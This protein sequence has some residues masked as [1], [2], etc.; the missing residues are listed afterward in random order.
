MGCLR[1]RGYAKGIDVGKLIHDQNW[2][3]RNQGKFY[4]FVEK[5]MAQL[6]KQIK[7]LKGVCQNLADHASAG[8]TTAMLGARPMAKHNTTYLH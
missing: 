8:Y 6:Q 4:I 7:D 1:T 2:L 5:E 3:M